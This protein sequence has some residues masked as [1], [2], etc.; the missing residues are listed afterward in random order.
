MAGWLAL[1]SFC[2]DDWAHTPGMERQSQPSRVSLLKIGLA[3][4]KL[5]LFLLLQQ[6][7]LDLGGIAVY[8]AALG[9]SF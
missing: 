8:Y 9:E 7:F 6:A 5:N 4:P 3:E 1:S 2:S